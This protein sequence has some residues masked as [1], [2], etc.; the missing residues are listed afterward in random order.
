MHGPVKYGFSAQDVLALEKANG[1]TNVIVDDEFPLHLNFTNS[2]LTAVLVN[3][4]KE[5]EVRIKTLE[6]A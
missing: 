1:G 3:A 4:I 5:L 6:D 2:N